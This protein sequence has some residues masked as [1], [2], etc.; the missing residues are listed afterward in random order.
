MN[1][2][3][4]RKIAICMLFIALTGLGY[5]SYK[6]LPVELLPNAELPMLFVQVTSA[7]DMDPS[8]VESEVVIPI[9]GAIGTIGGVEQIESLIDSRQSSIKIDFK[10]NINF[11][12]TALK[13]RR[14]LTKSPLLFP[15]ALQYRY[16]RSMFRCLPVASC[17]SRCVDRVVRTGFVT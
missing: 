14:R 15:K 6:Q 7:Q 11:K 10:S 5:V 1:F 17:R 2:L 12:I 4:H 13:L 8:Y 3:L 16:K 9:E